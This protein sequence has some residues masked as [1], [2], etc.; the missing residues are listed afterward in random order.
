[1]MEIDL[2]IIGGSGLYGMEAL[3]KKDEITISTPYGPPSDTI[4]VG[5]LY[6]ERVA[7]LARHGRGHALTP[8]E[9]PYRANIHA[10]KQLG[11]KYIVGVSACGSLREEYRPG[12]IVVPD[13]IFDHTRG[14][15]A[16]TFFGNGL[17]AHIG[18][19]DPFSP[20]LSFALSEALRK[21]SGVTV[22]HGGTYIT[23]EGPRFSTKAESQLYRKWGMDIVGMTTSPEVFLA[24]EA[25]I[26]YAIMAHVTDYD[27]WHSN[28]EPVSAQQVVKTFEGNLLK[29]Q[30]AIEGL[31]KNKASWAG[32]M[33][34]HSALRDSLALIN[35]WSLIPK[36]TLDDL[37]PIIGRY[38]DR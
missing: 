21:V 35:D 6:G 37:E 14:K 30:A 9:V 27:V 23:I 7:F 19:A 4:S 11:V 17:A 33:A 32:K 34:A 8:S 5:S 20:E 13:Q 25:E 36:E 2:A 31:V 16:H 18:V 10:L 24:N 15:R 29:A 22:H 26:A 3:D 28:A 38:V 12:H 1:M